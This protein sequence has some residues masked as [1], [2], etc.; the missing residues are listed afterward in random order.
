MKME[1][2]H[3]LPHEELKIS[4]YPELSKVENEISEIQVFAMRTNLA[5][6]DYNEGRADR[7][8]VD[9][10]ELRKHIELCRYVG[11][12]LG[13]SSNVCYDILMDIRAIQQGLH[14]L[15]FAYNRFGSEYIGTPTPLNE[16]GIG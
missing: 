13:R 14:D 1:I 8:D 7:V 6:A 10:E 5:L 3:Y 4:N 16:G 11:D 2:T 15:L 9:I 12:I